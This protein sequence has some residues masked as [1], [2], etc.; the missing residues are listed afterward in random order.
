MEHLTVLEVL[1]GCLWVSVSEEV[2]SQRDFP[3]L[4]FV[5]QMEPWKFF[6]FP[7][8]GPSVISNSEVYVDK[9]ELELMPLRN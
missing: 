3:P 7:S 9:S 5:Y 4:Y 6:I 2:W 8:P 1:W